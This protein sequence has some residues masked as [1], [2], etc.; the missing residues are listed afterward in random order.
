MDLKMRMSWKRKRNAIKI[1]R[2]VYG[3]Y[4]INASRNDLYDSLVKA[5]AD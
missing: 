4:S 3:R 1:T 2:E 5:K